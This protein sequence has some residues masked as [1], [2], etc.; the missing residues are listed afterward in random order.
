MKLTDCKKRQKNANEL[1]STEEVSKM[2]RE[3]LVSSSDQEKS[4]GKKVTCCHTTAK[5]ASRNSGSAN[6][7]LSSGNGKE[8]AVELLERQPN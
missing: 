1:K 8:R 2:N 7:N 6:N 4:T 3:A 5:P